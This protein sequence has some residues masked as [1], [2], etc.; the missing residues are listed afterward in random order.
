MKDE[1]FQG[2][3][4]ETLLVQTH[5]R[6]GPKRMLV[7]GLG[8]EREFGPTQVREAAARAV[9]HAHGYAAKTVTVALPPSSGR[10]R[11]SPKQIGA[12]LAEGAE[13]GAYKFTA[14]HGPA[15]VAEHQKR[16]ASELTIIAPTSASQRQLEAGVVS[17]KLAA[18]ATITARDLV[19]TPASDM[20]PKHLVELARDIA[21]K[22]KRITLEVF[23]ATEAKKRGMD[24]FLAVAKG[25]DE[26]PYFIHLIYKP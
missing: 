11:L 25:S 19:N 1:G 26:P 24:A 5:S 18:E 8:A 7:L 12:T 20:T 21:K 6:L 10:G 23:D 3:I 2:K 17:G 14:Y 9:K 22:N 15:T 13:L 16:Q 4:G